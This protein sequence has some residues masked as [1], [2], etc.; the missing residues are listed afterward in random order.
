MP[1]FFFS[2]RLRGI[3]TYYSISRSPQ[4]KDYQTREFINATADTIDALSFATQAEIQALRKENEELRAEFEALKAQVE[5][6]T[7]QDPFLVDFTVSKPS[8]KK[9]QKNLMK[10]IQKEISR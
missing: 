2:S 3:S 9:A 10:E 1:N 4:Q 6:Q 8:V 7:K 5:A